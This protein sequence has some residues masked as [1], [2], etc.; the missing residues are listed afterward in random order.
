MNPHRVPRVVPDE[1]RLAA[2]ST[3]PPAPEAGLPRRL[4][5]GIARLL[6]S[7]GKYLPKHPVAAMSVR[8]LPTG[9]RGDSPEGSPRRSG[10]AVV[11]GHDS[12]DGHIGHVGVG[13]G[14]LRQ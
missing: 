11:P 14:I 1:T 10:D 8:Y 4:H 7:Y 6:M 13:A 2:G 3:R 5:Y 12:S 9:P